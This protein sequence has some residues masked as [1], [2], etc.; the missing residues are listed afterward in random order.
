MVDN[1][2][3]TIDNW[4]RGVVLQF[5]TTW[6]GVSHVGKKDHFGAARL[7][8]DLFAKPMAVRINNRGAD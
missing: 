4:S 3:S 2:A 1:Y 8:V 6:S 5:V 7:P